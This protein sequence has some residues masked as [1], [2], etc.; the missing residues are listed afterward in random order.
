M[1][2]GCCYSILILWQWVTNVIKLLKEAQSYLFNFF[3]KLFEILVSHGS[4]YF[5]ITHV[6][7]HSWKVFRLENIN[8][9]MSGY[10]NHNYAY[11]VRYNRQCN[12]NI[13]IALYIQTVWPFQLKFWICILEWWFL[14]WTRELNFEK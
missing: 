13:Q 6:K 3:F 1:N 5:P 11:T 10:G 2:S 7:F 14:K 8:E 4:S 9:N 12:C